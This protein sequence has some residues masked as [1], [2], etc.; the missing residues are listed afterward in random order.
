MQLN[1]RIFSFVSKTDEDAGNGNNSRR[2]SN[3]P[4]CSADNDSLS[5]RYSP[6]SSQR[7][8]HL[9][10]TPLYLSGGEY[11]QTTL[12]EQTEA[13]QKDETTNNMDETN[14]TN[15]PE[16][17]NP[18]QEHLLKKFEY[19]QKKPFATVRPRILGGSQKNDC[20]SFL[21]TIDLNGTSFAMVRA[22]KSLDIIPN[23][24]RNRIDCKHFKSTEA[25]SLDAFDGVSM[26][27][28]DDSMPF[29]IELSRLFPTS[30]ERTSNR[31]VNCLQDSDKNTNKS[32][33]TECR[34][35]NNNCNGPMMAEDACPLLHVQRQGSL[36]N[37]HENIL[38]HKRWR[39]LETVDSSRCYRYD[40]NTNQSK[41]RGFRSWLVNLFQGNFKVGVVQNRVKGFSG[42]SEAPQPL[43]VPAPQH[44]SIV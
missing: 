22:T 42:F 6:K 10:R 17:P 35:L 25:N 39:S 37:P 4:R 3:I 28:R 13:L 40:D 43:D 19:K 27:S 41:T 38:Q 5:S 34:P 21:S 14:S 8:Q 7:K 9:N 44:E 26:I 33:K 36:N 31:Q 18:D 16:I 23:Q 30:T 11:S 32:L 29:N 15:N 2:Q 24:L 1:N 20:R 12:L